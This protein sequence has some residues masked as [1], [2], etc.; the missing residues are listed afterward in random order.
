MKQIAGYG[1]WKSPIT[2]DSVT[3]ESVRL[4]EPSIV[5]DSIYWLE[6]RPEEQ[7]RTVLVHHLQDGQVQD[8]LAPPW[9][10]RNRVNEYGGGAYIIANQTVYFSELKD[11]RIYRQKSSQQPQPVTP[12]EPWRFADYEF[13]AFRNRLLA[14]REDHSETDSE[15]VQAIVSI[16]LNEGE[17]SVKSIVKG[18]D[19]Y[20]NP[21]LSPTGDRMCWLEWN[22]PAMP[23]D[24][25]ELWVA[26]ISKDGG[27]GSRWKVAGGPT[28]SIFQPEWS[29]SGT[30]HFVS[31]CSGFWNLYWEQDDQIIP[32]HERLAEFGLP[33]WVFGMKTYG[34]TD[35]GRILCTFCESG[36]WRLAIIDSAG[37][38]EA[39]SS[40][41]C[42]IDGLVVQGQQAVFR[43]G[44]P[45]RSS[46]IV[47][48]NLATGQ[49]QV[50]R[51][52]AELAEQV[53]LYISVPKPVTFPT[54]SGQLVHAYYY[55]PRNPDFA[56]PDNEK[57][58]LIVK[59]HGG[60][61]SAASCSL[62]LTNQYFTS[63]GFAVLDV[64]YRGSTGFG[65][66]YRKQLS[67][68]WGVVDVE[69]CVVA[70]RYFVEQGLADPARCIIKGGS[71]GGYTVLCCLVQENE[72]SVGACYY[73]ISDL[74]TLAVSTHKFESHY[75]DSLIGPWPEQEQL[76]RERSPIHAVDNLTVP[77]IFFQGAKDRVVPPEQTE[78]M[79]E[80]LRAKN[81]PVIYMLFEN[82]SHGFR[83]GA[84]IKLALEAELNFYN[85]MV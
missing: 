8:V 70:T 35:D 73:G 25:S 47:K 29:P 54:S 56:A 51:R 76:Y 22:H 62:S 33:Q 28:E 10:A 38:L 53:K 84:N 19:F 81:I 69:D 66:N 26:E 5:G 1:Y 64:N 32:V 21:R 14:V 57:P 24:G 63:R 68:Q 42:D 83:D 65:R 6:S 55:P 40:G 49:C 48:F 17:T 16:S 67:R 80:A 58:P 30:L 4:S 72:F 74:A 85:T 45:D 78:R 41:Y 44:S 77:V 71:S 79:V 82:E 27:T 37:A 43:S 60:P 13:D 34:F 12:E 52:A 39:I 36:S 50:L 2:S 61:T 11:Q 7:G 15:A 3:E 20:S 31:D 75:T 59:V 18:A 46:E 23:W 9:Y